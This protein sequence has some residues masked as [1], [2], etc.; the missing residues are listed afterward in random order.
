MPHRHF[1]RRLLSP[2]SLL[3]LLLLGLSLVA[4][5]SQ[6]ARPTV[7]GRY[8]KGFSLYL[9]FQLSIIPALLFRRRL[10]LPVWVPCGMAVFSTFAI[11]FNDQLADQFGMT[12]LFAA[13]R[14]SA[15]LLLLATAFSHFRQKLAR[16]GD[17]LATAASLFLILFSII[18]IGLWLLVYSTRRIE[19]NFMGYRQ[20]TDF[21]A[22]ARDDI[23]LF[24]DS[25]VWGDGV[26][27][28]ERFGDIL[29]NRLR[30]RGEKSRVHSLGVR[31]AG[32]SRSLES[33]RAIKSPNDFRLILFAFYP[34]DIE[35]AANSPL[36]QQSSDNL[37]FLARSSLTI[38]AMLELRSKWNVPGLAAYHQMLIND[39]DPAEPTFE[40][41]FSALLASSAE[42]AAKARA[43]SHKKPFFLIIPLM[44]GFDNYPLEAMHQNLARE[45]A[46]QGF[47][48]IDLLPLFRQK[49]HD[50]ARFRASPENNHF[51][52]EV[53]KLVAEEIL[54]RL[55]IAENQP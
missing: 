16:P 45:S 27:Q 15:G 39:Y 9:L 34:N 21:S 52:A 10:H 11:A 44:V 29:E 31:G 7:L 1:A 41:R 18:D 43:R 14:L 5:A 25:F 22:F 46:R 26:G 8:S 4:L 19:P 33:I 30:D 38:R 23:L 51:N 28:H 47:E 3:L 12:L 49:L 32:P 36:N 54:K 42:F 50:G 35:P 2:N 40:R 37:W 48:V 53:H 20:A 55:K 13:I 6:S 24:G 17:G